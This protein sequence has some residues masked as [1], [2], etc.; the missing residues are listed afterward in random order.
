MN[1]KFIPV[2]GL[3]KENKLANP[4]IIKYQCN[5]L[6]KSISFFGVFKCIENRFLEKSCLLKFLVYLTRSKFNRLL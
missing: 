5:K 4:T 2:N 1:L 3:R 6:T